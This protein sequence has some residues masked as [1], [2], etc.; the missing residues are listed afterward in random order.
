GLRG[1][2]SDR[3]GTLAGR[4]TLALADD[5]AGMPQRPDVEEPDPDAVPRPP[6][7]T[8]A[9]A[10]VDQLPGTFNSAPDPFFDPRAAT[11]VFPR[12]TPEAHASEAKGGVRRSALVGSRRNLVAAGAGALLVA[13]L[14]TVVTLGTLSDKDDAPADRVTTEH[15]ASTDDDGD[16]LGADTPPD[17]SGSTAKDPAPRPSA[18]D[19]G[20]DGVLGTADD[21]TPS[22]PAS[23]SPGSSASAPDDEESKPGSGPSDTHKPGGTK[24]SKTTRPPTDPG[25]SHSSPS[26]TPSDPDE[27]TGKP[28]DP[29]DDPTDPGET[30][31]SEPETS[32]SASDPVA[33]VTAGDPANSQG[34]EVA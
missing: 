33:S 28:T 27:P 19:P 2:L 26:T 10:V 13:V 6:E 4:R 9:T 7:T 17:E 15:S 34:A 1:A 23:Q 5:R 16:G 30:D 11:E 14:G 18:T 22:A 20:E 31:P 3:R 12:Q 25:P 32:N 29:T 8:A 24:P 21:P